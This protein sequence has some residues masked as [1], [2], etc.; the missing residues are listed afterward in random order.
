M[1]NII[2]NTLD[3]IALKANGE[4]I[5]HHWTSQEYSQDE[6]RDGEEIH[7]HTGVQYEG[8]QMWE[9][10]WNPTWNHWPEPKGE[11]STI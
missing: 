4:T 11:A 10:S 1:G 5:V 7:L 2:S 6:W 8:R 9:I 3:K